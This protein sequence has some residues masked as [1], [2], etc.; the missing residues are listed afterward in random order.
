MLWIHAGPHKA[1]VATSPSGSAKTGGKLAAQGVLMD[2][3]DNC[4]ANAIAE[5]RL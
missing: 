3:D 5:K 1:P 4:L 2:G